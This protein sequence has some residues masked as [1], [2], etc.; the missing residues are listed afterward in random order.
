M[1]RS[2]VL[3][4]LCVVLTW[5]RG[6]RN[7]AQE[8]GQPMPVADAFYWAH[9]ERNLGI[10]IGVKFQSEKQLVETLALPNQIGV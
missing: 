7:E 9:S 5:S 4:T 3:A 8:I 1:E 10:E 2:I 6:V